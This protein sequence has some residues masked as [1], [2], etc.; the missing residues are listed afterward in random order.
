MK[1]SKSHASIIK[2]KNFNLQTYIHICTNK[3][4]FMR[5]NKLI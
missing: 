4:K 3:S 2:Q 5:A 1:S